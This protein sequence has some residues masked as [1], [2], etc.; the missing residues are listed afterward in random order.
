MDSSSSPSS[1]TYSSGS[2]QSNPLLFNY[3]KLMTPWQMQGQQQF[4]PALMQRATSGGM[5]P[6]EERTLLGTVR[7]QTDQELAQQSRALASKAAMS[8]ISPSS[9]VVIGERG[10]LGADAI[11]ARTNAALNFAKLKMGAGD[12]ARQQL[13]TALYAQPPYAVGNTLTSYS[14]SVGSGG[15][16]GGSK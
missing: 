16:G 14:S 13:L 1:T 7:Q 10:N 15:G 2:S 12:T 5:T 3:S 6:E 4:L 9:P 11:T 8:G